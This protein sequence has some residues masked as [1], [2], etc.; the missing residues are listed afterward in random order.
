MTQLLSH[1][2]AE[3]GLDVHGVSKLCKVPYAG[4]RAKRDGHRSANQG[5]AAKMAR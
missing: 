5:D 1:P 3:T 4:L 2:G